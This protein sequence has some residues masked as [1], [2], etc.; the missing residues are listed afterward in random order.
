MIHPVNVAFTDTVNYRTYRLHNH[1]QKYDENMAGRT[2]IL[3]KRMETILKFDEIG[4][5]DPVTVLVFLGQ[6]KRACNADGVS[7]F[8][9]VWLLHFSWPILRQRDLQSG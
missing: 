1:S 2:A 6:L 9:A 4:N 7:E 5:L 8:V 3:A